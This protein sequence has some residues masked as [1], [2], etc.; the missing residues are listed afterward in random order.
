MQGKKGII[1]KRDWCLGSR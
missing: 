1:G